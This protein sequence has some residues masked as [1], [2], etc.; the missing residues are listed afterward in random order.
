MLFVAIVLADQFFQS[1]FLLLLTEQINKPQKQAENTDLKEQL[2]LATLQ[3]RHNAPPSNVAVPQAQTPLPPNSS[4]ASECK[5]A[6]AE[7]P[8]SSAAVSH[9]I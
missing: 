1:L 3:Q 6:E 2:V 8:T 9:N 4:A 7:K 5:P